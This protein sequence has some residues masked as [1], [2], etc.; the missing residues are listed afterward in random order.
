MV[1]VFVH[2]IPTQQHVLAA[3][4]TLGF[5]IRQAG[6]LEGGLPGVEHTLPLHQRWGY[7]VAPLYAGPI[8]ELEVIFVT[9]S[10][11]L[12]VILWM[13]RRLAL[14]GITHQSISRFRIWHAG[15]R[16]AGLGRHCGRLAPPGDQPARRRGRARRLVRADHRVGRTSAAIPTSRSDRA[17]AWAAPP[18]APA[19]EAA[20]P[21]A[22]A[23][24]R[25]PGPRPALSPPPSHPRDL[26][27]SAATKRLRVRVSTTESAA[28]RMGAPAGGDGVS[29]RWRWPA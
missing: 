8:T 18:A 5:M 7:W 14:A 25:P 23:P 9:N 22:T 17:T 1:P 21:A 16:P 6:L 15:R 10:A 27:V 2:P 26:A 13:D 24:D 12:E 4:D 20:A 3:L 11:G 19:S 28:R 29:R